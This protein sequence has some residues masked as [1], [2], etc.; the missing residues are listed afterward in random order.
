MSMLSRLRG[1]F[2]LG[3][4]INKVQSE[5][6]EQ[7]EGVISD[8]RPDLKVSMSDEELIKLAK[9]WEKNW[10]EYYTEKLKERQKRSQTYWEGKGGTDTLNDILNM[11]SRAK[12]D[13]LIFEALET[14]LPIATRQNPDPLVVVDDSE[15]G[16]QLASDLK[17][18]LVYL[19]DILRAKLKMKQV[20]RNWALYFVGV[21]KISWS[22]KT[23]NISI[24]VIRPQKMI[25]DKDAVIDEGEYKGEFLGEYRKASAKNLINI[26]PSKKG[27]IEG[28]VED[29]EGNKNLGTILQY[30]EW[31]TDEVVFWTLKGEVLDKIKN[32]NWNWDITTEVPKMTVDDNGEEVEELNEYGEVMVE[33]KTESGRNHFPHPMKPYTFL[34]VFNLQQH[35]H[36]ATSLIEQ[37][38]PQQDT[39]DKRGQQIDAN[40]NN[41][42]GGWVVSREKAGLTKE[43][44]SQ[45]VMAIQKGG[46]VDIP[47]GAPNEAIVKITGNSLP[48]DVFNERQDARNEL[49]GIFGVTGSTAQGISN[50]ET[51]RGKIIVKGQ[52][53]DRIGG[54]VVE[55]IEQFYDQQYNWMIQMMYVHYDEEHY[56]TVIGDEGGTEMVK[57]SKENIDRQVTV[58][59]KEGSLIPKDSLTQR[60]EA[61]DLFNAGALDPVT[62]YKRLEFPNPQESAEKLQAWLQGQIQQ[63]TEAKIATVEAGA[64]AK[65]DVAKPDGGSELSK[66]PLN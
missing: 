27:F 9:R 44:A 65:A 51:V 20:V 55:Y 24:T 15:E 16:Q 41:M 58:S 54:G 6:L 64:Q 7:T 59:V 52:D 8:E 40:V 26:F 66:V 22:E 25:M 62:L 36:D 47:A 49:R 39:I 61:I 10:L 11:P 28:L 23:N 2:S 5:D 53:V 42:N 3:D 35:P 45:A 34:S 56:A 57:I 46:V 21:Q 38:I 12:Q 60:N 63:E 14:F 13:N 17:K 31:W 48:A 1:A 18:M 32:P 37:N 4:N 30:I 43:E 29:S 19:A 33:P 50:E